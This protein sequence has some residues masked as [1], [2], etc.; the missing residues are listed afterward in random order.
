[1]RDLVG[2]PIG[3]P[4]RAK[5]Q[6]IADALVFDDV[7]LP[8]LERKCERCHRRGKRKGDLILSSYADL[9]KGGK[10]GVVIAAGSLEHSELYRR[11][12]L[13][14]EHKDFMPNDGRRPLTTEETNVIKWWIQTAQ[15]ANDK[16]FASVNGHEEMLPVVLPSLD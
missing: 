2:P 11:I 14:P 4:K 5:P 1:M 6:T 16:K 12:T 8:I 7:V 9:M 13:D 3:K 10:D 15:A